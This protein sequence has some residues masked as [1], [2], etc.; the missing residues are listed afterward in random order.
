[1]FERNDLRGGFFFRGEYQGTPQGLEGGGG[2]GGGGGVGSL[3]NKKGGFSA[4]KAQT[5]D[6]RPQ[7]SA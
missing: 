3:S 1:M 5:P 7:P 2:G 6:P 4:Q